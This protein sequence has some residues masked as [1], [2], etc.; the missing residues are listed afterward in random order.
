MAGRSAL[1]RRPSEAARA[2]MRGLGRE[3]GLLRR[4]RG[5]E[6][7]LEVVEVR[8]T[9]TYRLLA[10]MEVDDRVDLGQDRGFDAVAGASALRVG[11]GVFFSWEKHVAIVQ[12]LSL[13]TLNEL[14][15]IRKRCRREG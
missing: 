7:C 4:V 1:Q 12:R 13:V 10:H 3:V 6:T 15:A 14:N 11:H 8:V 2:V 5:V 9:V